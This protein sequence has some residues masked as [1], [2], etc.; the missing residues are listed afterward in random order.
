MHNMYAER[1]DRVT[2]FMGREHVYNYQCL[3]LHFACAACELAELYKWLRR[4]WI[5]A[6]RRRHRSTTSD[7]NAKH[8]QF[9][10]LAPAASRMSKGL[11]KFK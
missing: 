4:A 1:S 2:A 11:S 8:R 6:R 7:R 10:L 9:S 5:I 3:C